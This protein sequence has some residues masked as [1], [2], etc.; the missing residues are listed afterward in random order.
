LPETTALPDPES[1]LKSILESTLRILRTR[2][3]LILGAAAIIALPTA[4]LLPLIPQR[5]RSEATVL[6]VQQEVPERYVTPTTSTAIGEALQAMTQEVLSRTRLM[7]IIHELHLYSKEQG[8]L[9]PEQIIEM[10]RKKIDITPITNPDRKEE[11]TAFKIAFTTEDPR[12]AQKVTSRLTSLFI[13]ENSRTRQDQATSTASFL[14]S[15]LEGVKEKLAEQEARLKDFKMQHLGELPEQQQSNVAILGTLQSQLQNTASSLARAEQQKVYLQSLLS[16][17]RNFAARGMALPTSA[18]GSRLASPLEEARAE[19]TRLQLQKAALLGTFTPEHPDVLKIDLDI[20]RQQALVES[21]K[22]KDS[23][24]TENTQPAPASSEDDVSTSQLKSQLEANR[25]EIENL[26]NDEH[27]LQVRIAEYQN[28]LN[29]TPVREQQL[30]DVVRDYELLK[31]SYADLLSKKQQ[32]QLAASLERQ[33]EG[34]HFLVIDPA[35]LPQIPSGPRPIQ[36][37]L[38]G[39]AA[40]LAMGLAIAVFLEM[41]KNAFQSEK[42]IMHSLGLV[43]VLEVPLMLS[44]SEERSRFWKSAFTAATGCI[45]VLVICATEYYVYRLG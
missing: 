11:Y 18:G 8:R 33:Q 4:A 44:V 14:S 32:S 28:R 10:M 31:L 16:G 6:V 37:S 23:A 15:E 42:E 24:K 39:A 40:G 21:L 1:D 3:L 34:Q 13:E 25:L 26:S 38:G 5:Y 9:A 35:N 30:A 27:K 45:L 19:L 29:A 22:P 43:L 12:I 7:E 36:I 2:S 17:Y 20:K 41:R